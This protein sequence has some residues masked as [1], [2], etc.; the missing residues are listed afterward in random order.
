MP[1]NLKS[2]L[3]LLVPKFLRDLVGE[4]LK[5]VQEEKARKEQ[6][7]EKMLNLL[8]HK[9]GFMSC[10]DIIAALRRLD[11]TVATEN[12]IW[13]AV[14]QLRRSGSPIFLIEQWGVELISGSETKPRKSSK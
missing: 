6:I 13:W 11:G 4:Y 2:M 7:K 10:P 9:K 12:D 8:H 1:S 5:K 14:Q 3:L